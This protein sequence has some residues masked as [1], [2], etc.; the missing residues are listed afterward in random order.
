MSLLC[1]LRWG[2]GAC[3][4]ILSP[5]LFFSTFHNTTAYLPTVSEWGENLHKWWFSCHWEYGQRFI[6]FLVSS[7]YI[8]IWLVFLNLS[9]PG[10]SFLKLGSRVKV[11]NVLTSIL[12]N[13]ED[14]CKANTSIDHM[15]HDTFPSHRTVTIGTFQSR[16]LTQSGWLAVTSSATRDLFNMFDLIF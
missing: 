13:L 16:H 4:G 14:I 7:L 6:P 12:L 3:G 15:E 5:F 2:V 8:C 1:E 10:G 9:L 11:G